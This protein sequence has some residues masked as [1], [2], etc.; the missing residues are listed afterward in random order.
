MRKSTEEAVQAHA[1]CRASLLSVSEVGCVSFQA[2]PYV[3]GIGLPPSRHQ[4][5]FR[6]PLHCSVAI[7]SQ[8]HMRLLRTPWM[9]SSSALLTTGAVY[10][11][12]QQVVSCPRYAHSFQAGL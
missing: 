3:L 4:V 10:M 8:A 9:A 6:F 7:L 12:Q 1:L 2:L 11:V 5:A